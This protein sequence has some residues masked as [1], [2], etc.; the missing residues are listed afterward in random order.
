[1]DLQG[2]RLKI[3][4]IELSCMISSFLYEFTPTIETP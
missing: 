1:M 3:S 4:P 2:L